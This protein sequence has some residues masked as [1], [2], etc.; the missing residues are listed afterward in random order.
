MITKAWLEREWLR[1]KTPKR[2]MQSR[3]RLLQ[4]P[5]TDFFRRNEISVIPFIPNPKASHRLVENE[6]ETV[7][8]GIILHMHVLALNPSGHASHWQ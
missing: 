4:L 7:L 3:N 6:N 8:C 2:R 1:S 5:T